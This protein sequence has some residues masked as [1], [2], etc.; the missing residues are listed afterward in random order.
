MLSPPTLFFPAHLFALS[1]SVLS[2]LYTHNR[3]DACL[4]ARH[5]CLSDGFILVKCWGLWVK[6]VGSL[7]LWLRETKLQESISPA[8][9]CLDTALHCLR[10]YFKPFK[11]IRVRV[12]VARM[13]TQSRCNLPMRIKPSVCCFA[14]ERSTPLASHHPR[15]VRMRL[16]RDVFPRWPWSLCESWA[17]CSACWECELLNVKSPCSLKVVQLYSHWVKQE[18]ALA[19]MQRGQRPSA[20]NRGG[21][22][23][24]RESIF[25]APAVNM[26][27]LY[28]LL[29]TSFFKLHCLL[30][31]KH[32]L[33]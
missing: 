22:K 5:R 17:I 18:A 10:G 12:Y 26:C 4:Y 19:Q 15:W 3:F 27:F 23:Q 2:S 33:L 6:I 30:H 31:C 8:S 1:L 25:L 11:D 21:P 32:D 29:L 14:C 20:Q 24:R 9:C 16:R 7:T 28:V 13:R